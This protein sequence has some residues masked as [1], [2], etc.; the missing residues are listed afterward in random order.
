MDQLRAVDALADGWLAGILLVC[1]GVLA[2][3]NLASPRQWVVLSRSFASFRLG[4]HRLREELN[5]RD[6]TLSGLAL[7]STAVV[8]LF[9]YQV[10]LYHGWVAPG[11]AAFL[12]V[13]LVVAGVVLAQ[14]LVLLALRLLPSRD[15]G[16][17]EYLFTLI[18]FH[19]VLGLLLLPVTVL[20]S[21]PPNVAWREWAW[22]A[23]AAI[24]AATV[25]FRWARAVVV[26]VGNGTPL[27]YIFIYLCTLEMLPAALALE[28][29]SRIVP[30][31]Q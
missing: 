7:M 27:R 15:G 8:A 3:V 17:K 30:P 26:G 22:L 21:F 5:M 20:M 23:G 4:R 10:L 24:V 13:L 18:V 11:S 12:R 19:V 29:V 14:V 9:A 6:R 2:W 25:L 1:T 28:H 16:M 31:V